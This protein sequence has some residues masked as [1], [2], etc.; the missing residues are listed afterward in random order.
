MGKESTNP[1]CSIHKT[2]ELKYNDDQDQ[3]SF[4]NRLYHMQFADVELL[5]WLL[6]RHSE[7][8]QHDLIDAMTE[9]SMVEVLDYIQLE[10]E[11]K[12]TKTHVERRCPRW[13]RRSPTLRGLATWTPG[14]RYQPMKTWWQTTAYMMLV[15]LFAAET[16]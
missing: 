9:E 14:W 7:A 13:T 2:L 6:H 16:V 10:K 3:I 15:E 4:D 1:W 8:A 12:I 5:I 11:Q